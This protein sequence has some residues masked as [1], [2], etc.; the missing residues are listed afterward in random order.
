MMVFLR[1]TFPLLSWWLSAIASTTAVP[2]RGS[3]ARCPDLLGSGGTSDVGWGSGPVRGLDLV[4]SKADVARSL[5]VVPVGSLSRQSAGTHW[6]QN[7]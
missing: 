6:L 5:V 3:T 1:L 4:L 2:E 7:S